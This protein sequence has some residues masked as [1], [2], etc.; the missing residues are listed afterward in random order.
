MSTAALTSAVMNRATYNRATFHSSV[1]DPSV[2]D[3]SVL[4]SS[5]SRLRLT[6]PRL[7]LTKRG[8]ALVTFLVIAGLLIAAMF[9]VLVGGGAAASDQSANTTFQYVTVE[10]GESLWQLAVHIAP[11]ADPR[12]VVSDIVHLNQLQTS[13]VQAGQR[14]AIPQQYSN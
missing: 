7:R 9:V 12:D 4:L 5:R 8:R 2:S 3:P 1:S 14:I 13:T 10:A 11:S 6:N